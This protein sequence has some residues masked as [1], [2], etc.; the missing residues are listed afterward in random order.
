MNKYLLG[1]R[2]MMH[3]TQLEMA[4]KMQITL[5]SY[6]YKE[7]GKRDFRQ[8][9]MEQIMDILNVEFPSLTMDKVFRRRLA[10]KAKGSK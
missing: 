4:T 7:N 1:Y 3:L 2:K 5:T 10:S 9:E 6:C 8:T